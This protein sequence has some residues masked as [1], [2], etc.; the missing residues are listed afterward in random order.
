MGP[1]S[2]QRASAAVARPGHHPRT[3]PAAP[4]S[5]PNL[6]PTPPNLSPV[7]PPALSP[8]PSPVPGPGPYP[9]PAPGGAGLW[10]AGSVALGVALEAATAGRALSSP[11]A[12]AAL[13]S[14]PR[15]RFPSS[16]PRLATRPPPRFATELSPCHHP[17]RAQVPPWHR[18][19]PRGVAGP[20]Q[21]QNRRRWGQKG[22]NTPGKCPPRGWGSGEDPP[23]EGDA[24]AGPTSREGEALDR[25]PCV[26]KGRGAGFHPV[27]AAEG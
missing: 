11:A 3:H 27:P 6:S 24:P 2:P 8:S 15:H 25:E 19:A 23:G 4:L 1:A 18:G 5:P 17:P 10:P 12:R 20:G 16:S 14:P 13:T 21:V 9:L 26:G 7:P 22:K